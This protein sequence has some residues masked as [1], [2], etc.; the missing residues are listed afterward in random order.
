M[1][2]KENQYATQRLR[3]TFKHNK[4]TYLNIDS[5]AIIY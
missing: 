4:Y 3:N 1:K 5:L 2:A